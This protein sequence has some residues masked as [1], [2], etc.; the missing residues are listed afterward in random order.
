MSRP[1]NGSRK[2]FRSGLR[3]LLLVLACLLC[4]PGFGF[5]ASAE[6]GIV[7]APRLN[8][9]PAPSTEGTPLVTLEK[10]TRVEI[11]SREQGWVRVRYKEMQGYVRNRERYITL[12]A[13]APPEPAGK[14]LSAASIGQV[15]DIDAY[16]READTINSKI[17]ASEKAVRDVSRKEAE[18]IDSLHRSDRELAMATRKARKLAKEITRLEEQIAEL[19][20]AIHANVRK[21]QATEAHASKRLVALYKLNWLGQIHV[22]ASAESISDFFWRKSA[23]ERILAADDRARRILVDHTDRISQMLLDINRRKKEKQLLVLQ[24]KTQARKE[25]SER[26]KRARLLKEIRNKKSLELAAVRS[27]KAAARDLDDKIQ[28]LRLS[29]RK[30]AADP[31]RQK[32]TVS[33]ARLKGLLKM[34]VRGKIQLKFGAYRDSRFNTTNFRSG[35]SISADHGEPIRAVSSGTVLFADW[36]KGYGNMIIIDHGESYYTLY[37]HN[38]ELFK[39]KGDTVEEGE[40]VATVGDTGSL[41]APSLHFEVRHHGRPLDPEDW[42]EKG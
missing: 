10:G 26:Q 11:L 14:D 28:L 37:A 6:Y 41:D 9:R 27:L 8:I 31:H 40:V 2:H 34:P 18:L 7:N 23:I 36:F 13:A 30:K 5:P 12:F 39:T 35:V 3:G 29:V 19:N 22:L 15:D 32:K 4:C 17:Q 33:F 21:I 1:G 25:A 38:E 16:R 24:Y 42:L 20:D